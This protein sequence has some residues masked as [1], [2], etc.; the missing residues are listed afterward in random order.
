MSDFQSLCVLCVYVC[1][2]AIVVCLADLFAGLFSLG[3]T[4]SSFGQ[5]GLGDQT[6]GQLGADLISRQLTNEGLGQRAGVGAFPE[7]RLAEFT[8]MLD[9]FAFILDDVEQNSVLDDAHALQVTLLLGR[10]VVLARLAQ[11]EDERTVLLCGQERKRRQISDVIA[12]M[13]EKCHPKN[14]RIKRKYSRH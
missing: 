4:S 9:T 13:K 10:L 12:R 1:L 5:P 2:F 3:N 7:Q 14:E 11:I 8:R 6:F